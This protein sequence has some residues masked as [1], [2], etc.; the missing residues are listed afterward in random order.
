MK[1]TFGVARMSGAF[2]FRCRTI[3]RTTVA[4]AAKRT[5]QS[6]LAAMQR[7][8]TLSLMFKHGRPIWT[9][10]DGTQLGALVGIQLVNLPQIVAS[11][12]GLFPNAP[13][14]SFCHANSAANESSKRRA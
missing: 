6:A 3:K 10:S 5:V 1:D 14:Q 12:P 4:L 11:D 9:L 7:G 2:S 8:A 13:P